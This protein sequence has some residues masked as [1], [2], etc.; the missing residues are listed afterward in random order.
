[1]FGMQPEIIVAVIAITLFASFVK[2]AV[3]FAMPIIMI[4]G[5]ASILPAQE[6]LAALIVPTV[7]TN[8]FQA[9]R[10]GWGAMIASILNWWRLIGTTCLFI[11]LSSQLV[12]FIP[13]QVLLGALGVPIVLFAVTQLLGLQPSFHARNRAVAEVLTG[14]VGGFYGGLSG[15]WGPPTIALLLS[16]GVEKRENVRVQG[17]VY[18]IGAL[19]LFAGHLY[20]GVLNAQTLPLSVGLVL[21]S[22]VGLWAG[23][24]LHDRL[25]PVRF[26][27]WTLVILVVSGLNLIRRALAQ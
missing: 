3:G 19:V 27:R 21:P 8:L 11:A 15:V 6:A 23:F 13:Q 2:G 14:V 18:L 4:S 17:I 22:L 5:L 7:V 16:L 12:M 20:S 26:R 24:R 25:D 10:Q 1:M 9:F